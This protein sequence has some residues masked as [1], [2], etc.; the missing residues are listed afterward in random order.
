MTERITT[1][2]RLIVPIALLVIMILSS[3]TL[4]Q[5]EC[6]EQNIQ[7]QDVD[8]K[9]AMFNILESLENGKPYSRDNSWARNNYAVFEL[10]AFELPDFSEFNFDF[11]FDFPEFDFNSVDLD[12]LENRMEELQKKIDSRMEDMI[13]RIE[14]YHGKYQEKIQIKI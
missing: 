2:K 8:K 6:P 12:E 11:D 10:P 9:E 13:R 4:L 5:D 1:G 3:F 14:S 7:K